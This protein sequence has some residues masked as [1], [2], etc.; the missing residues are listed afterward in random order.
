[1]LGAAEDAAH[2][3]ALNADAACCRTS[4][5]VGQLLLLYH[6]HAYAVMTGRCLRAHYCCRAAAH[7]QTCFIAQDQQATAIH[8]TC[9]CCLHQAVVL[10]VNLQSSKMSSSMFKMRRCHMQGVQDDHDGVMAAA[11]CMAA[12]MKHCWAQ[13]QL[14]GSCKHY[15]CCAHA[16][17]LR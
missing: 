5:L 8:C 15:A 3:P 10:R 1:M 6:V 11:D 17:W 16:R 4:P 12:V 14:K 2:A 7:L 9:T 13:L